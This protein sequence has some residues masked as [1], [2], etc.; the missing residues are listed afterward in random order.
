MAIVMCMCVCACI[1]HIPHG[2]ID[3]LL[4]NT[5]QL[6]KARDRPSE[7]FKAF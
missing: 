7:R 5:H 3:A 2:V 4:A 1:Y 6:V